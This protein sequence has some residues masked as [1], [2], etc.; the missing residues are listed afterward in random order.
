MSM[1]MELSCGEFIIIL[2]WTFSLKSNIFK[3]TFARGYSYKYF[4]DLSIFKP[5]SN[6]FLTNILISKK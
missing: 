6:I 2:F 3:I 5:I 1:K 4:W